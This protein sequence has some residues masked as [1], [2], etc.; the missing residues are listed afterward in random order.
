[1]KASTERRLLREFAEENGIDP[2]RKRADLPRGFK[3]R[4]DK[5]SRKRVRELTGRVPASQ[6]CSEFLRN[7]TQ[8]F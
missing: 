6:A 4:S 1:M 3:G 7:Q 5:F 2:V 8:E